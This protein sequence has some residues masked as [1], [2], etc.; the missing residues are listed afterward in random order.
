MIDPI[1]PEQKLSAQVFLLHEIKQRCKV[2][3]LFVSFEDIYQKNH[4]G[5]RHIWWRYKGHT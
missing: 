4:P 5:D 1:F 3:L 2:S